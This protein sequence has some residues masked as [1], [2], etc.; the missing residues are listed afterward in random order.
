M[1]VKKNL[2]LLL[3][4]AFVLTACSSPA[5]VPQPKQSPV[6]ASPLASPLPASDK[7]VVPFVIE[8][9][10]VAGATEV[11]GSGPSGVPVFIADITFMGEPLGTGTIG[12]DGKFAIQVSPLPAS[13]RIG[14]ALGVLEGTAWKPEDFYPEKFFGPGAMQV[15]QVG[16]FHDTEMVPAQ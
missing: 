9:P 15:P 10:L 16:F 11:R 6:Q 7:A 4:A 3:V 8:R 2:T 13:H 12:P 1:T 5:P 14:I